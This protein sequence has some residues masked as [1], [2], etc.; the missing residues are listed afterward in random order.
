MRSTEDRKMPAP[1]GRLSAPGQNGITN[2]FCASHMETVTEAEAPAPQAKEL[3]AAPQRPTLL[4]LIFSPICGSELARMTACVVLYSFPAVWF[5]RGFYLSDP[6]I[7]W[8]VRTGQ[9]IL[10]HH[11]IPFT[12]PFSV[13]GMG[14][15][16]IAYSWLFDTLIAVV[17]G[18]FGL[19]GLVF[20]EIAVRLA[21]AVAL[22]HLVRSLFSEFW[23]SAA[24]TGLGLFVI[25]DVVGPRPGML[26]IL[27][28]ILELDI[29]LAVRRTGRPR[30]LCLLPVMFA[31]WVNW[32]IQF[33]Y[34]LLVLGMF[35]CEPLM[36]AVLRYKPREESRM[37]AKPTGWTLLA[38]ALAT[39]L[40][41]YGAKVYSTVFL[42]IGQTRVY[43]NIVELRSMTFREPQHFA[44]LL[45]VLSAA[46]AL[47]WRRD[48]RPLWL[49]LL[50]V[51]AAMAFRSTK[52]IWLLAV[53]SVC[54]I[55]D[56]WNPTG[57]E[58]RSSTSARQR[59]AVAVWI[60]AILMVACRRY[61]LSKDA[62]DIQVAGNFP[63]G[64]SRF[65]EEHQL[66]GPLYNHFNW[67]GFLIWRLPQLPVAIDGRTNVHGQDRVLRFSDVWAG[68][69]IWA[70]DPDLAQANMV[71]AQ[72]DMALTSLLR[73]DS[74]FKI[75][76]EDGQAVVFQHH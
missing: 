38:S 76:Y 32:H 12:D 33:V 5:I 58:S 67:G 6:D 71:I 3:A 69:P 23:R 54:V 68:K 62:L 65:V 27:F 46:M 37:L 2:G 20:Y 16:W 1:S 55:A 9:W 18:H 63:E 64:A 39:L 74:R 57:K 24:L 75:V 15:P 73:A 48:A 19:L 21:L 47:G 10:G 70:S 56:G 22:F 42:Y 11:A 4:S 43:N 59:V 25:L 60:L 8:H 49:I 44:A 7:W 53:V 28:V 51:P 61:G 40:N 34:G 36:N 35:A 66:T 52:D 13:Y 17:F 41:P 26:T 30:K 72:R 45:L 14:K 50:A 29:L 31:I